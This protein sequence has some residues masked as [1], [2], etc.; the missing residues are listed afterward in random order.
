MPTDTKTL[1]EIIENYNSFNNKL[2]EII[3]KMAGKSIPN[4]LV[5]LQEH[6]EPKVDT[7]CSSTIKSLFIPKQKTKK[8]ILDKI[9]RTEGEAI[10]AKAKLFIQDWVKNNKNSKTFITKAEICEKYKFNNMFFEN[11]RSGRDIKKFFNRERLKFIKDR[12]KNI[13][14]TNNNS[15][16]N[17]FNNKN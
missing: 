16:L 12:N 4:D 9:S 3:I 11:S 15:I 13:T 7:K 17:L 8:H 10:R 5:K 1:M 14:E 2:V 6:K